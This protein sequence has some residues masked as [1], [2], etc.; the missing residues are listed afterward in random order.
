MEPAV[1][2]L[3]QDCIVYTF[4]MRFPA[5]EPVWVPASRLSLLQPDIATKRRITDPGSLT[6]KIILSCR[7]TFSVEVVRQGYAETRHSEQRLLQLRPGQSA[8][9][10]AVRLCCGQQPWVYAHTV[11][12]HYSLHRSLRR[13]TQLGNRSLGAFLHQSRR[14]QRS[15]V[16]YARFTPKHWLFQQAT[17]DLQINSKRLWGRRIL[18]HLDGVPLLV[19]ELFLP[20]FHEHSI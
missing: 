11:I 10:R 3:D 4:H 2:W 15:L 12:P 20:P 13:L 18:F 5:S 6:Q 1:A 9:I 17:T 14:A 7:H 16:E 19:H 8:N